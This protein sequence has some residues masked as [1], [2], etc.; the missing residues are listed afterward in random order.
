MATHVLSPSEKRPRVFPG[1]PLPCLRQ[2]HCHM[3]CLRL[4][5]TLP[6][7][8]EFFSETKEEYSVIKLSL[9]ILDTNLTPG[10]KWVS[11]QSQLL[12]LASSPW[13]ALCVLISGIFNLQLLIPISFNISSKILGS[14]SW[15][16]HLC[17]YVACM[18]PWKK[19]PKQISASIR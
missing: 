17:C 19:V 4:S 6:L 12:I 10:I 18:M 3:G 7:S 8:Q 15:F 9:D 2:A 11:S 14:D 5:L 1:K 16:T 13:S